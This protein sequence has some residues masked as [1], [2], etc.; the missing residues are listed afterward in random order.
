MNEGI[1]FNTQVAPE[2]R[3]VLEVLQRLEIGTES[4]WF[5]V[6]DGP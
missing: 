5:I 3:V 6:F 2:G 1:G 4:K